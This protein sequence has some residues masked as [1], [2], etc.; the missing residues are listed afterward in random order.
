VSEGPAPEPVF[1]GRVWVT[2]AG[3]RDAPGLMLVHGL[4]NAGA[5]D[6]DRLLPR[7]A[8]ERHV[9]ALDLPGFGRSDRG[10]EH[11]TPGRY[12]EV[13]GHLAR[14]RLGDRYD[15][16]GHSL[17]GAVALML[18]ARA[19][20]EVQRLVLADVAGILHR[21]AYAEQLAFL[22]L[23]RLAVIDRLLD[24]SLGG[25]LGSLLGN[26]VRPVT[27]LEPDLMPLL[28][29]A[30]VRRKLLGG[31]PA[32]IAALSLIATDFGPALSSVEAA[33]LVV[34]GA[35]DRIAPVRT[36]AVLAARIPGAVVEIIEG[37]GHVPRREA[38]AR[39]TSLVEGW[40]AAPPR[41]REPS[42]APEQVA[43]DRNER[44]AG[45]VGLRLSGE[46]DRLELHDCREAV[47]D[48]VRAR[49]I[50][51]AG[52]S[53]EIRG[54]SVAGGGIALQAVDSQ[55]RVTGGALSGDVALAAD[56]GNLDLAGVTLAGRHALA[57]CLGQ[58]PVDLLFSVCAADGPRGREHLHGLRRVTPGRDL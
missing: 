34:W 24:G 50:R 12:A 10:N 40:L 41:G 46:F 45:E 42:A 17:G 27:R 23:D 8:G 22:G 14:E 54:T 21:Q 6:F 1:G 57:R 30:P 38:E 18:A 37:C 31:D 36:A 7:L 11:Y 15:L 33:P 43:A 32:K 26:L 47:V 2:E 25:L 53:V 51:V 52:S 56:G 39:F 49:S 20:R 3:P 16:L 55:V 48:G 13:V 58:R 9:V 28:G 29:L 44:R 5:R 19:P 4:G 35:D